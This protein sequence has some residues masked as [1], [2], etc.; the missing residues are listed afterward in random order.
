MI[1]IIQSWLHRSIVKLIPH[2][3]I[4]VKNRY[5]NDEFNRH[6]YRGEASAEVGLS[7]MNRNIVFDSTS[8]LPE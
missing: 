3:L 2:K 7:A 5:L 1:A 6:E 8:N 4:T